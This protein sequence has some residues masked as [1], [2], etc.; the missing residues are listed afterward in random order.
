[1]K[2]E[3]RF[4]HIDSFS[5][6][7]VLRTYEDVKTEVLVAGKFSCFEASQSAKSAMLFNRLCRDPEIETFDLGMPWTGVRLKE[8]A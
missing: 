2:E 4:S 6:T 8:D 5:T 7:S 3:I 1:M